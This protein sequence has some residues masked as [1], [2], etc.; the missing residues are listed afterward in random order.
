LTTGFGGLH[1]RSQ[2]LRAAHAAGVKLFVPGPWG[3]YVE[4][5][6]HKFFQPTIAMFEEA[7]KLGVS[8]AAFFT[9]VNHALL[10]GKEADLILSGSWLEGLLAFGFNLKEGKITI[11]GEGN[12]P[13]SVISVQDIASFAAHVLATLPPSQ[14]ENAKFQIEGDRLV[15][16]LHGGG[17]IAC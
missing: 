3:D 12:A 15:C 14:L 16:V 9:S 1:L 11:H 6:E 17:V 8:T 5:R 13:V 10:S 7:G 2:M 4:G